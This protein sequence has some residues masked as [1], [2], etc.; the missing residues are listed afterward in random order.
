M[1]KLVTLPQRDFNTIDDERE[2]KQR[3]QEADAAKA[4]ARKE[5][6][7]SQE[8]EQKRK[9]MSYLSDPNAPSGMKVTDYLDELSVTGQMK[10]DDK[11][12]YD[13]SQAAKGRNPE[14]NYVQ[15]QATQAATRKEQELEDYR[16]DPNE[17]AARN[18]AY[19]TAKAE[20]EQ[21]WR[22][23]D[24]A[25]YRT[26]EEYYA[27]EAR[28]NELYEKMRAAQIAL[29]DWVLP[30][31]DEKEKNLLTE[32]DYYQNI[33][34]SA[35]NKKTMQM[36]LHTISLW[37]EE[38][39]QALESIYQEQNKRTH[40]DGMTVYRA[41]K[42]LEDKYGADAVKNFLETWTRY[43]NE[44]E[45][46]AV[47]KQGQ[48]DASLL[49]ALGSIPVSMVGSVTGALHQGSAALSDMLGIGPSTG[50]YTGIDPNLSGT[51][52]STYAENV[53]QGEAENVRDWAEATAEIH[54]ADEKTQEYAGKTAS[55]VFKG[56]ISALENIAR[57]YATGGV[58]SLALAAT[59]GF[60]SAMRSATQQGATSAQALG[61][62][63]VSGFLEVATEKIPLDNLLSSVKKAAGSN[64]G[65]LVWEAT[66]QAGIEVT[67]EEANFLGG[68][69]AEA[70]ILR[71]K[72][73]Y[74]QTVADLVAGGMAYEQA[75]QQANEALISEAGQIALQT[76]ISGFMTSA[77]TSVMAQT[78]N[79]SRMEDA[80]EEYDQQKQSAGNFTQ[81][82][83]D[84][85][86]AAGKNK[87]TAPTA[88]QTV[89]ALSQ[90][91]FSDILDESIA[92]VTGAPADPVASAVESF[93][94]TGTVT[95]KQA[96]DIM[97]NTRAIQLLVKEAGLKEL[98]G[99]A[100]QN[101]V[102]VKQAVMDYAQK[103][104]AQAEKNAGS[105][106][107][108]VNVTSAGSAI[109]EQ[110][111]AKNTLAYTLASNL[112]AVRDM[113]PVSQL[114]GR[115]LNDQNIKLSDQIRNFF[116][117]LGNKVFRNGLGEV[118]L[119]EYGVGGVLNHRPINRAKVVS[120][121]A[122]PDVIQNG[123]Q[124]GY[125]PNWKGRGYE[126][127]TFAAPVTVNGAPVYVAAV[128]NKLPNNKF[129]LSEMVDSNGNYVR[130]E[131]SPSGNSKNGLPMGPENQQGRDYAGP[132]ELPEGGNPSAT[133]TE[134][135]PHFNNSI[136]K[137][138]P[139][140]NPNESVGAADR[141]FT[142]RAAYQDLLSDENSQRDRPGDV[143]PVEVPK[144]DGYGRNV[145]EFVGNAYGAEATPDSFVPV[146]EELVQEGALGYDTKTNAES[147]RDAAAVIKKKGMAGSRDAIN[148]N[149][150]NGKIGDTDIA[151]AMLLYSQYASRKGQQAQESA[152]ELFVDLQ[153]MATQT[154]RDLQLFKML[155][156]MTPQGQLMAITKKVDR[157]VDALNEGRS[158]NNQAE[159]TIPKELMDE[160]TAAAQEAAVT[161]TPENQQRKDE[162]EQ[163]IYAYAA[164]NIPATL[165]EKWDSWR[166][167]AMLGNPKTQIRNLVGN[168]LFRPFVDT[169][170]YLGT[171][172]EAMVLKPDQRT[173]SILGA[174]ENSRALLKWAKQDAKTQNVT[175]RMEYTATT[176]DSANSDIGDQRQIFNTKMLE[177]ARTGL[178]DLMSAEDM[179][180]KRS[181][182][183]TSM[184]SF[185]KARGI[186]A[187]QVQD[188]S[189]DAV[190]LEAARSYAVEE[191][192]KATFNDRNTFSDIFVH[193][194]Y[195]GSNPVM[196]VLNA[197][198]EGILPFRR[199][200]AN[201]VARATEY[202]P[203]GLAKTIIADSG[204]VKNGTLSAAQ[205]IDN[206]AAGLTG[207]GV[208][209]L[210]YALAAGLFEGVRLVGNEDDED[211]KRTGHQSYAL[212]IGDT[213]VTIDWAAPSVL[214]LFMGVN[215]YR[216]LNLDDEE[217]SSSDFSAFLDACANTLEPM[218]E[219]S[220]LSSLNDLITDVR[221]AE[222]G[223]VLYSI[224]ASAATSYFM[225]GLPTI[226]GQV[227]QAFETEKKSVYADASD[228]VVREIQKTVGRATQKIPG[229]D[230]FQA[231]KVDAWG[232]T[233]KET[234]VAESV[235]DAFI[236]PARDS[237]IEETAV[238]AEISRLNSVQS[239][240]VSP[241]TPGKT[242]TYT[243]TDGTVR[244]N[245]RLTSEEYVSLAKAQGQKQRELVEGV[246]SNSAYASLSDE[247]KAAAIRYAYDYARD[248]ARGEVIE[249][250]P[251]VTTK[252]MV[253]LD[254]NI[255]EGILRYV[256]TGT[257]TKYTELSIEKAS[258]VDELLDELLNAPRE[259]KSDGSNYTNVRPI[260][261]VEA[262][263]GADRELTET[264]QR[265][266]LEDILDEAAY[267]K[268][269]TITGMGYDNDD[270]A[271]SYRLYLDTEGGKTKTIKQFMR[272]LDISYA[273]AKKLYEVYN[274]PKK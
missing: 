20:Y 40:A 251:G 105:E 9:I 139:D 255:A 79:D 188:G 125:D 136:P 239:K 207:T 132:E 168:A 110:N 14:L 151:T 210:G 273:A 244:T 73:G 57:V 147:L 222:E 7:L 165:K 89:P 242:I 130:I 47:A 45:N 92:Q 10:A 112:D 211:E 22:E 248:Y 65:D 190:T 150:A 197:A 25:N 131:E 103:Q 37:P 194:R 149:I 1:A 238:D 212:E 274:P 185:L 225:Q 252:W 220:C 39:R 86:Y 146:I 266:V 177:K 82:V 66:K 152:A 258:F 269:K 12:Y 90:Q 191:A 218:L 67:T 175:D 42:H 237:P 55:M 138:P 28:V 182:Y 230:L 187:Q 74:R 259:T 102:S 263:V 59:S 261:Q 164:A 226:G 115:E 128:V 144:V 24:S 208:M 41:Q 64:V 76:A 231:E 155:R 88:A 60:S 157:Y 193:F 29:E 72:S 99:T 271:A 113:A 264:Q 77:G 124:I 173:K 31:N 268:Y 169:K 229:V 19:E 195:K 189:V 257:T 71:E 180:F 120:L 23:H 75:V 254:G 176:G 249:G 166:Y 78:G 223:R 69:L 100:S 96:R 172:M 30:V 161:D 159:V 56:G 224:A 17:K 213:S 141:N 221:Y 209:A 111:K 34:D 143:R 163:A 201:I 174:D 200:P 63:L 108:T 153:M 13:A 245:K 262:V 18:T 32:I 70:V 186:T 232:E 179:L 8:L 202:S 104:T 126:S 148:R 192:M 233:Q 46:A 16:N 114:T 61:M 235:F 199:T 241:S 50:R 272:E 253:G 215:L 123:R 3:Q 129:Y 181:T 219:L 38:D 98:S 154:G 145:S 217:V 101:R 203:I 260:Q 240:N 137:T 227:E 94:Q 4:A 53:V 135:T 167:L 236:N 246:I 43:R 109:T 198:G 116:K 35:G 196:K 206:L 5:Q 250:H 85:L 36:D 68:V 119:G 256:A 49:N 204:K 107:S 133:N 48:E 160:Y 184:A 156:K 27:R 97:N 171:A 142:G 214:P 270:F 158:K 44:Q 81:E 178:T 140:V 243:G 117:S 95:N 183:A 91:D 51:R 228:P 247:E 83:I 6:Q 2:K 134:P 121:A 205:Y 118:E 26:E 216:S 62:G 170:R 127:Y 11:A 84:S 234:S 80:A 93:A 54:G 122:V 52:L 106:E 87:G 267:G 33:A 162:A 58:G 265:Q 15:K 21:A